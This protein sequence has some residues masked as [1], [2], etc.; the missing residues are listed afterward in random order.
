[1]L[2]LVDR[3]IKIFIITVFYTL[4]NLVNTEYIKQRQLRQKKTL[5]KGISRGESYDVQ[6]E[7]YT[8]WDGQQMRLQEKNISEL[9]DIAI[10]NNQNEVHRE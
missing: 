10:E 4:K 6:D 3:D 2:K 9:E 8:D 7:K 5:S 1:M